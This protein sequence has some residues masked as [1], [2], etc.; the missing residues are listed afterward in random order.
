MRVGLPI[1]LFALLSFVIIPGV[2][3]GEVS[4]PDKLELD[5]WKVPWGGRPRDPYVAPDGKVWFCGQDGNYI[6]RFDPES[7]TFQRYKIDK[8]T[9]PHN[10][11]VDQTG[12]VWYAGNR[13]AMIGRLDPDNGKIQRYPMPAAIKDPHTLEFDQQGNIWFTAQHSNVIGHLT[14]KSGKIRYVEV[15]T[16][17]ARPYGIRV[18]P[19][20]RPWIVLLG[21]NKLAT[22]D[23]GDFT[24]KEITISRDS[25]RPRRLEIDADSAIWFADYRS[26]YLGRYHSSNGNF[27]YWILPGG[28][29]SQPYGTALDRQHRLWVALTGEYPNRLIGFDTRTRKLISKNIVSSGGS[30]RHM[31]YHPGT[32]SIWFGVDS[33]YLARARVKHQSGSQ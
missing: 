14:V 9:H 1:L 19:D 24:L 8:G 30:V 13:N 32:D 7:G 4:P 21:T 5:E 6:A 31:H 12:F 11:I 15:D 33:G 28:E 26:G 22:V 23:P 3:A 29:D 2:A 18:G 10:L 20:N 25:V 16:P 27:D 17:R